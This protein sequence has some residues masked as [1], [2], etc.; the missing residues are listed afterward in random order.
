[1]QSCWII[2]RKRE[3]VPE[4]CKKK[5]K[6]HKIEV[7]RYDGQT[8]ITLT[9][10]QGKAAKNLAFLNSLQHP[11]IAVPSNKNAKKKPDSVLFH[12]KT[13]V[14][15][16]VLDLVARLYSVKAERRQ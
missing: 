4:E 12:N 7:F 11:D 16:D 9:S 10:Y 14:G 15:V 3:E 13:K 8:A 2:A 6:L 1:M 5:K